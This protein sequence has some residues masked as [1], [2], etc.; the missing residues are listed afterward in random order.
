[1]NYKEYCM[2]FTIDIE[3][4][5]DWRKKQYERVCE[6]PLKC[7]DCNEEID[8]V[9]K[10]PHCNKVFIKANPIVFFGILITGITLLGM[11]VGILFY[12]GVGA[13]VLLSFSPTVKIIA[14]ILIISFAGSAFK[15]ASVHFKSAIGAISNR[16]TFLKLAD[17]YSSDKS[18]VT[19]GLLFYIK[20]LTSDYQQGGIQYI[21]NAYATWDELSADASLDSALLETLRDLVFLDILLAILLATDDDTWNTGLS[22]EGGRQYHE[23][24]AK[25]AWDSPALMELAELLVAKVPEEIDFP[26]RFSLVA[27][28]IKD[29]APKVS[30]IIKS[31]LKTEP[32]TH[33][34]MAAFNDLSMEKKPLTSLEIKEI[35][36]Y[37]EGKK[38]NLALE[39]L[40]K[41]ELIEI[42]TKDSTD[43]YKL[44]D[45]PPALKDY[46][47][48]NPQDNEKIE[49][50][51]LVNLIKGFKQIPGLLVVTN[52]RLIY[53][54]NDNDE[55]SFTFDLNP[56]N[57]SKIS[58][59]AINEAGFLNIELQKKQ[60]KSLFFDGGPQEIEYV[61]ADQF[62]EITGIQ[63]EKT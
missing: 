36:V 53:N 18:T 13:S 3:K 26:E 27:K 60:V 57:R 28:S 34:E 61:F 58:L 23:F 10:C 22:V 45:K 16:T 8:F 59:I 20:G 62:S 56:Q 14:V 51:F 39:L 7:P 31:K 1:M 41:R 6:I 2:S 49:G 42:E 37:P 25:A 52:L 50:F 24:L 48:H 43:R 17:K 12:G 15:A 47:N 11:G 35:F 29:N 40:L 63:P 44:C 4:L 54:C 5:N 30:A 9:K 55:L 21:Y 19:Q 46:L 33:D 32:L 38:L